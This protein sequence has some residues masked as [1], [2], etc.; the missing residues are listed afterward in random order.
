MDTRQAIMRIPGHPRRVIAEHGPIVRAIVARDSEGAGRTMF[1]HVRSA[2]EDVAL[3][4]SD[5]MTL[6]DA[7]ALNAR[8]HEK[9]VDD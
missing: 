2:R 1:K 4:L 8:E 9:E 6:E 3:A 7:V 5:G